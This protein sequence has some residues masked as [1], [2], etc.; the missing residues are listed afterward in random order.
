MRVLLFAP[1]ILLLSGAVCRAQMFPSPVGSGG[2]GGVTSVNGQTGAVALPASL[3]ITG[4]DVSGPLTAQTIGNARFMV[5]NYVALY[6]SGCTFSYGTGVTPLDCAF[7]DAAHYVSTSGLGATVVL[8]NGNYAAGQQEVIPSSSSTSVTVSVI[9]EGPQSSQ[10]SYTGTATGTG[11]LINESAGNYMRGIYRGFRVNVN[12]KFPYGMYMGQMQETAFDNIS[13]ADPGAT[14]GLYVAGNQD[15]GNLLQELESGAY[16]QGYGAQITMAVAAGIPT[17]VTVT[18]A[19]QKY[20]PANTTAV[21]YGYGATGAPDKA[22]TT[23][24]TVSLTFSGA[25]PA[26]ITGASVSGGTGCTS[27]AYVQVEDIPNT[28]DGFI[29]AASDSTFNYVEAAAAQ[30]AIRVTGGADV[31]NHP[32]PYYTPIGIQT[33]ATGLKMFGLECDSVREYCIDASNFFDAFGTSQTWDADGPYPGAEFLHYSAAAARQ[34]GLFSVTTNSNQ[35]AG[36]YIGVVDSSLGRLDL[37][38]Y[39]NMAAV[40]DNFQDASGTSQ[41]TIRM[42]SLP[43]YETGAQSFTYASTSS[44]TL[45]LGNSAFGAYMAFSQLRGFAGVDASGSM[46]IQSASGH[47]I[48]FATSS[49]VFGTGYT[50]GITVGG[51]HWYATGSAVT[52]AATITPTGQMF[53]MSGATPVATITVPTGISSSQGTCIHIAPTSAFTTTTGGNIAKA[54]TAVVGQILNECYVGTAWYPSY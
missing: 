37:Y 32:H 20:D 18:N 14:A 2:G 45:S 12:R 7:I 19:G 34:S 43:G 1:A 39:N 33:T 53:A 30:V 8:G 51:F 31:L 42:G 49:S 11:G 23:L 47:S 35:S 52:A 26:T 6:P 48:D 44:P 13:I 22:C 21:V 10:I 25:A 50:S 40:A 5:D 27:N 16:T 41:P 29:F 17:S 9:G 36:G 24:P 28:Q 38:P 4:G 46:V 54:S 3:A 15:T